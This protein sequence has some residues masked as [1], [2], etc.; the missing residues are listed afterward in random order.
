MRLG[1][2]VHVFDAAARLGDRQAVLAEPL[3]VEHDGLPDLR[4]GFLNG[5]THGDT[6]GKIR[7]VRPV[8]PFTFFDYDRKAH[9]LHSG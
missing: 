3:E 1:G 6:A 9:G 8:V 5:V 4:Q 7:N 2:D